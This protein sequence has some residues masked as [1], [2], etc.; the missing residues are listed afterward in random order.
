MGQF[1]LEAG[2]PASLPSTIPVLFVYGARDMTCQQI[3][4]DAMPNLIPDLKV[5]S[6]PNAAHWLLREAE[7][8][9]NSS[10]LSFLDEKLKAD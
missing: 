2:L 8:E 5:V 7:A 6:L 10:V 9:V 4:V 1:C 3:F